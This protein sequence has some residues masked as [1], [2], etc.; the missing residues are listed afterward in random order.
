[1]YL[2][3]VVDTMHERVKLTYWEISVIT[4]CSINNIWGRVLQGDSLGILVMRS[5]EVVVLTDKMIT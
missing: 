3:T 1:M 5:Y 2:S 4:N